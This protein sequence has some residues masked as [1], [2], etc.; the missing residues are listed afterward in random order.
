MTG[1]IFKKERNVKWSACLFLAANKSMQENS[2]MVTNQ[3]AEIS[4]ELYTQIKAVEDLVRS[5]LYKEAAKM[6]TAAE[7]ACDNLESLMLPDNKIQANIISNRRREITW[8]QDAIQHG[9]AN[10]KIKSATKKRVAKSK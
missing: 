2:Q 10:A 4:K 6:L 3:F 8:T 9:L 7:K 5:N 1:F